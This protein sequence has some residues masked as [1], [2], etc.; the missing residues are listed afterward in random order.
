MSKRAVFTDKELNEIEYNQPL[1]PCSSYRY[2]GKPLWEHTIN[3]T[4]PEKLPTK[5][6]NVYSLTKEQKYPTKISREDYIKECMSDISQV[7]KQNR[8]KGNFQFDEI[9]SDWTS[10][11]GSHIWRICFKT[12]VSSGTY[13]RSLVHDTSLKTKIPAHTFRITRVSCC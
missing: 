1:P 10:W 3:N 12:K 11:Q 4:L 7:E 2:K 5:R 8:N 6:V 13:V 9:K